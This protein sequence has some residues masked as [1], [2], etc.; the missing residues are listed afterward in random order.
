MLLSECVDQGI[1][2]DLFVACTLHVKG[3]LIMSPMYA[4]L[5][6]LVKFGAASLSVI[7]LGG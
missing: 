7:Y 1:D 2:Y 6:I 5:F 4:S 3:C